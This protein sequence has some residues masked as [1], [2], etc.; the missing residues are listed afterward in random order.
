MG[1]NLRGLSKQPVENGRGCGRPPTNQPHR[2]RRPTQKRMH[3]RKRDSSQANAPRPPIEDGSE[4]F[5]NKVRHAA[6]TRRSK[7]KLHHSLM[8]GAGRG[9]AEAFA[10]TARAAFARDD[11]LAPTNQRK[12]QKRSTE[13]SGSK[14]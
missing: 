13:I 9:Q 2:V 5:K 14:G 6:T 12:G 8:N 11:R 3:A 7:E 10:L 1:K 4:R